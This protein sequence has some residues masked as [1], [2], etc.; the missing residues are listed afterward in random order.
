M[1]NNK[2]DIDY[3]LEKVVKGTGLTFYFCAILIHNIDTSNN[4][5]SNIIE[6]VAI[7]IDYY[8]LLK[9]TNVTQYTSGVE[10]VFYLNELYATDDD[11][12]N[13]FTLHIIDGC[14]DFILYE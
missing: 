14:Y 3:L 5:S 8:S 10:N 12:D 2:H 13:T 1:N 7:L 4:N 6:N 11:Q 9:I